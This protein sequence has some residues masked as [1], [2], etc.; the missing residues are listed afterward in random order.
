[1]FKHGKHGFRALIG[2]RG[3]LTH[4]GTFRTVEE[5][6]RA[7]RIAARRRELERQIQAQARTG[8]REQI[9]AKVV[10]LIRISMACQSEPIAKD[11]AQRRFE[12]ATKVISGSISI[13]KGSHP[14]AT[15]TADA[16]HRLAVMRADASQQDVTEGAR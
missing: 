14:E 10:E 8:S 4:L 2:E 16:E 11:E 7:Y 12:Y 3:K 5:A 13:G 1:M 15:D 9:A 6:A